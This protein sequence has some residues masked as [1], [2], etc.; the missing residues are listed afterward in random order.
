M[1][2]QREL[3]WDEVFEVWPLVEADFQQFYQVN[4]ESSHRS[5]SWRWFT[6]MVTGLLT[7]DSRLHRYFYPPAEPDAPE[8]SAPD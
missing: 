3:S 4:L 8:V 7:W 2:A 6:V 1:K 5:L